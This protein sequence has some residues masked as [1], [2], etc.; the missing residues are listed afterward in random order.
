LSR[1]LDPPFFTIPKIIPTQVTVLFIDLYLTFAIRK[2]GQYVIRNGK[3]VAGKKNG[4][5]RSFIFV[6]APITVKN[7]SRRF[8][9]RIG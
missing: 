2:I 1:R 5:G 3:K 7:I 6:T 9:W 8:S 4:F